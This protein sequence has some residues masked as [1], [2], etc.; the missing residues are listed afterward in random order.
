MK[1]PLSRTEATLPSSGTAVREDSPAVAAARFVR[2]LRK[3]ADWR[4]EIDELLELLGRSLDCHRAVV[5]H[6]EAVP[7]QDGDSVGRSDAHA[8]ETSR[9]LRAIRAHEVEG[10]L[11]PA[12]NNAASHPSYLF[13]RSGRSAGPRA[14]LTILSYLIICNETCADHLGRVTQ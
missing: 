3:A 12:E 11:L 13:C 1:T 6:L 7:Q 10:T 8:G 9:R 4:Q 14:S 5:F 2:R